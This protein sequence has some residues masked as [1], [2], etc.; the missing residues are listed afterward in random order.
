MSINE[1]KNE[2][3]G[4]GHLVRNIIN[5]KHRATKEPL[6]LFFADLEQQNN[7]KE[8]YQLQSLQN[9]KSRVE[10]KTQKSDRI[11]YTVSK[12]WSHKRVIT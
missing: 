7:N 4:K 10:P 12:L 5:V 9:C 8:I 1:I 6:L 3:N 2:L 11:M